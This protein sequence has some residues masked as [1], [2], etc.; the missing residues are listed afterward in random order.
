R[1]PCWPRSEVMQRPLALLKLG[2]HAVTGIEHEADRGWRILRGKVRNHLFHV[3]LEQHKVLFLKS[4][5]D[6]PAAI[7][8][9]DGDYDQVGVHEDAR[10]GG[11][12][13]LSLAYPQEGG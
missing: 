10:M 13:L 12:C 11:N 9:G 4:G 1:R 5:H 8:D 6:V 3:I 2:A 7:G